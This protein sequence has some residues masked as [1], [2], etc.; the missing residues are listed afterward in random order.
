[1]QLKK[2]QI[3]TYSTLKHLLERLPNNQFIQIH[4][5][6]IIALSHIDKIENDAVWIREKQLPIG[7]TYRKH[8]FETINKRQL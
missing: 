4:K 6:Y 1:M 8:F 7:N 3:I 2:E 5:S